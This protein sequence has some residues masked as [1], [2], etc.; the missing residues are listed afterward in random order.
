[1][2]QAKFVWMGVGAICL[3]GC[4]TDL[5]TNEIKFI[6]GEHRLQVGFVYNLPAA[7][8]T[9]S[10]LIRVAGCPLDADAKKALETVDGQQRDPPPITSAVFAVTGDVAVEQVAGKQVLIDYRELGEFLKTSSI[11]F[12][13]HPNL[14]LKSVNVTVEDESPA[15]IANLAIVAANI[16]LFATAPPAA[17]T[18]SAL[19]NAAAEAAK[20]GL[21][22][23]GSQ[24][25]GFVALKTDPVTYLAC[26]LETAKLVD[27]RNSARTAKDKN[28]ASL[29]KANA[30]LARILRHATTGVTQAEIA[31]IHGYRD[32]ILDLTASIADASAAIAKADAKLGM[33]LEV[34]DGVRT[35]DEIAADGLRIDH[36][37]AGSVSLMASEARI[38]AFVAR[39]FVTV[40]AK[41]PAGI[42]ELFNARACTKQPAPTCTAANTVAPVVKAMAAA[43]LAAK[44]V[45]LRTDGHTPS[46]KKAPRRQ[47]YRGGRLHAT[48]GII[49]VE[50]ARYTF[51]LTQSA[52]PVDAVDPI[53][54]LK[55][56]IASV[57]QKGVYLS[58]PVHAG[59][60]EKV[61]LKA[62]FNTDGSLATGSYGR[63]SSAGKALSASLAGLSDKALAT[64]DAIAARKLALLNAEAQ[65]LTAQKAVLDAGDK[66]TPEADEAD[67]LADLNA[68]IAVANANATLAEAN[69]RLMVANAKLS[70]GP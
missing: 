40:S 6:E 54:T 20:S 37:I 48:R 55:S 53:T 33:K 56:V 65:R 12:E 70:G 69:V 62:T 1:M 29:E 36:I 15:L 50:P 38:Q 26:K 51:S 21:K 63:P 17:R 19:A 44:P 7:A 64:N 49:Y 14:M 34:A 27:D 8:V 52:F 61:E 57:P 60:G 24:A 18:V 58:L 68:Q 39:H 35:A 22:A 4:S 2:V 46:F 13:R 32:Q 66:L 31:A 42:G 45:A 23:M 28:T 30:A 59:F 16:A 5:R 11:G 47:A 43:K 41:V 3:S 67:P 10:G 9:S 25:K